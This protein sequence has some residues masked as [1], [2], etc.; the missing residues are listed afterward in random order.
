LST[1][2]QYIV[3][4]IIHQHATYQERSSCALKLATIMLSVLTKGSQGNSL[5]L[6]FAMMKAAFST[7]YF[8]DTGN[9]S[10]FAC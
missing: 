7:E 10:E 9:T 5:A 2:L 1:T 8:F 6:R 4:F 3:R